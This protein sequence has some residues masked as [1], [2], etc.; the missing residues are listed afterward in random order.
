MTL[1]PQNVDF[2]RQALTEFTGNQMFGRKLDLAGIIKSREISLLKSQARRLRAK[3]EGQAARTKSQQ[4]EVLAYELELHKSQT[5]VE[6]LEK[7]LCWIRSLPAIWEVSPRR[8]VHI[9]AP[10]QQYHFSSSSGQSR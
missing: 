7:Y 9:P 2:V 1:L 5:E 8:K 6:Q 3:G 10:Q 4:A